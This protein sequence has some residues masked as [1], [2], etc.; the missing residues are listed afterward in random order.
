METGPGRDRRP[1]C[2]GGR[3]P[4]RNQRELPGGVGAE[5]GTHLSGR[6]EYVPL[7]NIT[8][9]MFLKMGRDC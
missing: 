4:K 5:A 7:L 1:D 9:A 6:K 8:E 2:E 3:F